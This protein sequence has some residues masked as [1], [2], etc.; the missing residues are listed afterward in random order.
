MQ[1]F[2]ERILSAE[3]KYL[4]ELQKKF[5]GKGIMAATQYAGL[6]RSQFYNLLKRHNI[7]PDVFTGGDHADAGLN[8]TP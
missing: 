8:Q 5:A 3:A 2:H 4:Q 6:P 1:R 7:N